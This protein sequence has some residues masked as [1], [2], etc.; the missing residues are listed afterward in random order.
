[1]LPCATASAQKNVLESKHIRIP[2]IFLRLSDF[3]SAP[4]AEL[5]AQ[6]AIRISND[7]Y[8]SHVLSAYE[9][10]KGFPRTHGI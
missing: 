5:A 6:K 4:N 3:D 2:S 8:G 10:A 7:L 9:H 1:M